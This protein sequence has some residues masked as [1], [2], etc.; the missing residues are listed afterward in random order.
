ME[1]SA[2][3]IGGRSMDAKGGDAQSE[4]GWRRKE[5]R[6]ISK[7][8]R[9]APGTFLLCCFLLADVLCFG[10]FYVD[11]RMKNPPPRL[12]LIESEGCLAVLRFERRSSF[13]IREKRHGPLT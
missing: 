2:P 7:G 10:L 3:S 4:R 5:Q 11:L 1:G 9:P 13:E 12:I 8:F 6:A